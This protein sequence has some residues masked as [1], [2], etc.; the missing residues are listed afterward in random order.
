MMMHEILAD[1]TRR[2]KLIKANGDSLISSG[3]Y[4]I[5]PT[6]QTRSLDFKDGRTFVQ[7]F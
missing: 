3:S 5:K 4:L 1:G 2:C 6:I 7:D